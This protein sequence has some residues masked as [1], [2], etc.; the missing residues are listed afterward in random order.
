MLPHS[1]ICRRFG[2]LAETF[3]GKDTTG[4]LGQ[5]PDSGAEYAAPLLENQGCRAALLKR[6]Q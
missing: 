3:N 2:R 6:G 5:Q 4:H 1:M